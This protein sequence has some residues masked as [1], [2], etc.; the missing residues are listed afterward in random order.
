MKVFKKIS[1]VLITCVYYVE[2]Y[3][4]SK[5]AHSFIERFSIRQLITILYI[6]LKLNI[7]NIIYANILIYRHINRRGKTH[8]NK[9]ILKEQIKS[10]P[11]LVRMGGEGKFNTDL[12]RRL[13]WRFFFI[14]Y[15]KTYAQ[16]SERRE[17]RE[18]ALFLFYFDIMYGQ[19]RS[20]KN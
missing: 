12:F 6:L 13:F 3:R 7:F 2:F 15:T 8:T 10:N 4:L 14:T 18:I 16:E 19:F 9:I 20:D 11:T 17:S 1:K 5:Y